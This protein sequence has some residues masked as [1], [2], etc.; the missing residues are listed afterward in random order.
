MNY[1]INQL[2]F[3]Y[4]PLDN[5]KLLGIPGG[6]K[7]Q[8]IIAKI[9]YHF[10]QKDLESIYNFFLLTFSRRATNDFIDKGVKNNCKFI[11]KGKG[12]ISMHT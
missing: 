7:T 9:I 6:G 10:E 12:I 4:E 1:N 8:S 3:I 11:L 5:M 2:N